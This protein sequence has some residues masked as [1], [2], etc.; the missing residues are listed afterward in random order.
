MNRALNTAALAVSL[1]F[2]SSA[3]SAAENS[4]SKQSVKIKLKSQ[5]S[6][7]SSL[8]IGTTAPALSVLEMGTTAPF[9]VISNSGAENGHVSYDND[10]PGER[11]LVWRSGEL[12]K[13]GGNS[14]VLGTAIEKDKSWTIF[15]AKGEILGKYSWSGPLL[16]GSTHSLKLELANGCVYSS[17]RS[18]GRYVYTYELEASKDKKN[19]TE[20]SSVL[21]MEYPAPGISPSF[22]RSILFAI[23]VNPIPFQILFM[24]VTGGR[25]KYYGALGGVLPYIA[26]LLGGMTRKFQYRVDV[27]T[28][29]RLPEELLI[30][31]GIINS[32]PVRSPSE[33]LSSMLGGDVSG[34][35]SGAKLSLAESGKSALFATTE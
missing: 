34:D 19:N 12:G 6:V 14:K 22:T 24:L 16:P 21:K 31:L 10:I 3:W 2:T 35:S 27:S 33:V 9:T 5:D 17:T 25:G 26:R 7:L 29:S 8:G 13:E 15:S 18:F 28:D 30:F 20:C 32:I 11:E 23:L 1:A 4:S